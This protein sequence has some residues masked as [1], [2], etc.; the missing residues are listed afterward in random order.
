MKALLF[1]LK[2]PEISDRGDVFCPAISDNTKIQEEHNHNGSNSYKI[3]SNNLNKQ[4]VGISAGG[5]VA[6]NDEFKTTVNLPSGYAFDETAMKFI[7]DGGTYNG[8][9]VNPRIRKV[10]DS[11]M[12][13]FL[14]EA[15]TLKVMFI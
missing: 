7:I 1:G 3:A 8:E 14:S 10:T 5:W 4:E 13:V 9:I 2:Q 11:Q 6:V 12:E 15:L